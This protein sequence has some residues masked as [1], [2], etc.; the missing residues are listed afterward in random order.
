M[1]KVLAVLNN[2]VCFQI[3]LLPELSFSNEYGTNPKKAPIHRVYWENEL[4]SGKNDLVQEESN[5]T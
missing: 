3:K 4:I 1:T 5:R 2:S